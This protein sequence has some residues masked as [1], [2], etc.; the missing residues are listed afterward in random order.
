MRGSVV[1]TTFISDVT[2]RAFF[3][4]NEAG[5]IRSRTNESVVASSF[6]NG[7]GRDFCDREGGI[8]ALSAIPLEKPA[9]GSPQGVPTPARA[10]GPERNGSA[11]PTERQLCDPGVNL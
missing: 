7:D 5:R 8:P 2:V 3:I 11:G 6:R 9:R 4:K 1:T 10:Q